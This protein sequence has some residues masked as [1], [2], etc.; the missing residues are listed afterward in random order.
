MNNRIAVLATIALLVATVPAFSASGTAA[1]ACAAAKNKAAF[2]Q[3][4]AKGKCWQAALKSGTNVDSICLDKA[5]LKFD[6]AIAKADGK[7]GCVNIN[8]ASAIGGAVTSCI[9]DV[10]ALTPASAACT[11]PMACPFGVQCP[12]QN[13]NSVLSTF[14][15]RVS[16][17]ALTLPTVLATGPVGNTISNGVTPDQPTCNLN[18]SA[19]FNWLMQVDTSGG[20]L[21]V[22][23][24]KPVLDPTMGYSFVNET[25]QS[26]SVAPVTGTLGLGM[27]QT[28]SS[29]VGSVTI[30]VYL[31]A[32]GAGVLLLPM[33][34]LQVTGQISPDQD[35]IG[36]YD[37]SSLDPA[38]GCQPDPMHPG[39]IDGGTVLAAIN[40][41]DADAIVVAPLSESLCVLLSGD[42][43][44]Y[45]DG[46]SPTHCKRSGGSIVFTGDYCS[47]TMMPGGCAD[48]MEFYGSYASAGVKI[49]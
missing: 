23:G 25:V 10:L 37:V 16:H 5:D 45:G 22:G 31:D 9:N 34:G 12:T 43:A 47:T 24:A 39:W 13:D 36:G 1:G 33:R 27:N 4:A 28:F 38:A 29:Q 41:E 3:A 21:T 18:G 32:M 30:P 7:G 17:L 20:N 14:G 49:N 26:H 40:L 48:S 46:A 35:C 11:I 8:D 6:S 42:A 2:Q 19:T 15:L 44:T